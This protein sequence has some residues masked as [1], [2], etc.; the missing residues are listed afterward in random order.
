MRPAF[1]IAFRL[2]LWYASSSMLPAKDKAK[3][4]AKYRLHE[5]D[6]GSAEVQIAV[7]TEEM[8]R[9][10]EHLKKHPKDVHSRRGLL[11]KVIQRKRLLNWLKKESTRRYHTL[12]KRLK[13]A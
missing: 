3:L 11:S 13:L 5:T 2:L 9:L 6:T 7:L 8:S 4:I 1:Q 12:V 10:A